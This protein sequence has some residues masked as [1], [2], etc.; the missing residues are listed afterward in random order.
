MIFMGALMIWMQRFMTPESRSS[1]YGVLFLLAIVGTGAK[2]TTVGPLAAAAAMWCLWRLVAH[3]EWPVRMIL[4]G[5]ALGAGFLAAYLH[6]LRGYSGSGTELSLFSFP[7]VSSFWLQHVGDWEARFTNLGLPAGASVAVAGLAGMLAVLVGMNG[8]LMLGLF[9]A[10]SS[11]IRRTE[12][13]APWLGLVAVACIGF[14][15]LLFL[16]SHG[17]AYLYLPMKLPLA[18]LTAAAVTSFWQRWCVRSG[19]SVERQVG[20]LRGGAIV[21]V[22]TVVGCLLAASYLS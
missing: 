16:D 5:L 13:F 8:V 15:N 1:D 2:G 9:H 17:E 19:L 12:T 7:R 10:F 4:A 6:F 3:R 22:L 18:V 20:L 21:A 11:K 14:G